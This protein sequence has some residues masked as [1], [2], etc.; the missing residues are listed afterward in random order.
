MPIGDIKERNLKANERAYKVS[1]F[2]G[3]FELVKF[4]GSKSLISPT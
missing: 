4:S 3:S 2:G 1:D